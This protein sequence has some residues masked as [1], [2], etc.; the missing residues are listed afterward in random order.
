M[1]AYVLP[2]ATQDVSDPHDTAQGG[3]GLLEIARHRRLGDP[4]APFLDLYRR[5]RVV[6]A[7]RHTGARAGADDT[8]H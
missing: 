1:D 7:D 3:L 5:H 8:G 4:G 2:T 6:A